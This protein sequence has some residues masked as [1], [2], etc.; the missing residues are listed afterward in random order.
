MNELIKQMRYADIWHRDDISL[1]LAKNNPY[2]GDRVIFRD[3]VFRAQKA[4]ILNSI[5]PPK[6]GGGF[7]LTIEEFND[8]NHEYSREQMIHW[9]L[10]NKWILPEEFDVDYTSVSI[11]DDRYSSELHVANITQKWFF[12]NFDPKGSIKAKKKIMTY[13]NKVHPKLSSEAKERIAL[14]VNPDIHKKGGG[15]KNSI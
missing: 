10:K 12:A 6:T 13:L 1:I 7:T 14:I 2:V 4:G 8:Y 15:P 11:E 5:N 9:I 3:L